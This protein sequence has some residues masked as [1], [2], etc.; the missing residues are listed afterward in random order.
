[1]EGQSAADLFTL[2]YLKKYSH[3][4]ALFE[5]VAGR[6]ALGKVPKGTAVFFKTEKPHLL[7]VSLEP[8]ALWKVSFIRR[9]DFHFDSLLLQAHRNTA[10]L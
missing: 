8:I 2:V 4:Q 5:M 10:K 9:T 1:M 7:A 6:G 3:P